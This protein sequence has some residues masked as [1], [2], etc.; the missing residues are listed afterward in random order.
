MQRLPNQVRGLL[1][2]VVGKLILKYNTDS[3]QVEPNNQFIGPILVD[4]SNN[5]SKDPREVKLKYEVHN[6][7]HLAQVGRNNKR[8]NNHRADPRVLKVEHQLKVTYPLDCL[9]IL[10]LEDKSPANSEK[11]LIDG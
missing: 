2:V 7:D 4:R 3:N 11:I 8:S 9:K 1:K 6:Q 5:L 10:L